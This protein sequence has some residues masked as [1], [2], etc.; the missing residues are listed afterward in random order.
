MAGPGITQATDVMKASRKLAKDQALEV[1]VVG[2]VQDQA[3]RL[4][5]GAKLAAHTE[6]GNAVV[7]VLGR[8]S[9]SDVAEADLAV[10]VL[11]EPTVAIASLVAAV[12][13][14]RRHTVVVA[15][16][17]DEAERDLVAAQLGVP[18][19][20]VVA[21]PDGDVLPAAAAD[22]AVKLVGDRRL[23]LCAAF[24]VFRPAAA[25]DVVKTTA[26]QNAAVATVL[27]V[28][29]ADMP[30]LTANQVKMVLQL[31]AI[32]GETIGFERAKEILAVVGSGFVLR[33]VAR[34][35]MDFIPGIGWFVKG[36]MAYAGT[37]AIGTAA[38]RY[39]QVGPEG[40]AE[41]VNRLKRKVP[42]AVGPGPAVVGSSLP[43]QHTLPGGTAKATEG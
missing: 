17:R 6:A 27:A 41:L 9:V 7:K 24:P 18:A 39:F 2:L 1:R 40:F 19:L 21:S 30:V 25:R 42:T 16:G 37:L 43:A 29:G 8:D 13:E 4:L 32:H 5:L 34:E 15:L 31:A 14:R 26:W 12:V 33:T 35:L 36:G 38:E 10:V 20:A 11:R 3:D 28:P 22:R 23:A